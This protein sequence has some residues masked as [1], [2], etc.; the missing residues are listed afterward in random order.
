MEEEKARLTPEVIESVLLE[1]DDLYPKYEAKRNIE[2]LGVR[3]Y[4]EF[5]TKIDDEELIDISSRL[6]R[7]VRGFPTVADIS[8]E[9]SGVH[10]RRMAK[11]E[12]ESPVNIMGVD[13]SKRPAQGVYTFVEGDEILQGLYNGGEWLALNDKK[14]GR[15]RIKKY[16]WK[17][18]KEAIDNGHLE[19]KEWD[20]F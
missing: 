20:H 11:I 14:D 2:N 13:D 19:F 4:A 10:F 6:I 1:W 5:A 17:D 9:L 7:R 18:M 8:E 16:F 3:L 15:P 12:Y